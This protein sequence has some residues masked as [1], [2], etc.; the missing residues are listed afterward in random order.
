MEISKGIAYGIPVENKKKTFTKELQQ[1]I[2][3]VISN[4]ISESFAEEI[5][6]E[7]EEFIPQTFF[8]SYRI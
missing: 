4:E 5:Y 1:I 7:M 2:A 8:I 6:K 3:K